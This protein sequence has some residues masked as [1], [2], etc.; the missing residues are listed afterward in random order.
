M[1]KALCST[2]GL[3]VA[4]GLLSTACG[5]R[6]DIENKAATN[7]AG[8]RRVQSCEELENAIKAD[9]I[10]KMNAQIDQQIANIRQNGYGGGGD[11]GSGG[12]I[13]A[14]AGLISPPGSAGSGGRSEGS[15][16]A[17][18]SSGSGMGGM[19]GSGT[20]GTGGSAPGSSGA[21]GGSGSGDKPGSFTGTNTQ[22]AGV[23]EAD[24]VKTDG[25]Y[26]YLLHGQSFLIIQAW[27]ASSLGQVSSFA[28]EGQPSEMYVANGKAVIYSTVDGTPEY[29][30]AGLAPRPEYRDG[31]GNGGGAP[32]GT[33][34]AGGCGPEGGCGPMP[35][36]PSLTKITVV[37]ITNNQPRVEAETY[38]EGNYVSSRRVD[39][40]VR[41]VITGGAHGPDVSYAPGLDPQFYPRTTEDW[42][43][44]YEQL[45]AENAAKIARSTLQDWLPYAMVRRGGAVTALPPVCDEFYV[46]NL[47]TTE[48]GFT[49]VQSINLTTPQERP[50][51]ASIVAMVD[52]VYA[53]AGTMVLA[54]RG[55]LS[56]PM[57]GST[58]IGRSRNP[59]PGSGSG[60]SAT[61]SEQ[62]VWIS[63]Q[64]THLHQFD[65]AQNPSTP[66]YQA[67]GTVPGSLL[68]QFSIDEFEGSLRVAVTEEKYRTD[69]Y[70]FRRDNSIYVLQVG[71]ERNLEVVG[72]ITGLAQNEQLYATRFMG[73]R[74]YVVTFRRTDPLFVLDLGTPTRPTVLGSVEIPGFSEYVHPLDE[75]HLLTIGRDG[76]MGGRGG[77]VLLQIFDV[78]QPLAPRQIQTYG[79]SS[80]A[81]GYS[82]AES[83][84]KAFTYFGDR[85]LLAFPFTANRY[86]GTYRSSLEVFHVSIDQGFAR[87]GSVDHSAFFQG[88]PNGYCGGMYG[89]DVRRGMFMD[90]FLYSISYG[91]ILANNMSDLAQPVARL[92]LPA[93]VSDPYGCPGGGGFGGAGGS[94]GAAGMGGWAG[95]GGSGG[96]GGFGP[97]AGASTDAGLGGMGGQ[98]DSGVGGSGGS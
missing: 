57:P 60:G 66:A 32:P 81:Y 69:S 77:T 4:A 16:G 2:L 21:G 44:A 75:N 98:E 72:A 50:H 30:A 91:G 14:D 40:W 64:Q 25:Q 26:I 76:S 74:G 61:G 79:F 27:P 82:E 41:T 12:W 33:G 6:I 24:F 49:Q 20:A 85:Q 22:V 87:L 73:K 17:G 51:G 5:G 19:G 54:A 8:L 43:T 95:D 45:R 80:D 96:M 15:G 59:A 84:H 1:R 47:G 83:N 62:G 52:T 58:P 55:W 97:D 37:G 78:S 56:V 93:P 67:S 94:G 9:A 11:G 38:F 39:A 48:Y 7:K 90:D 36:A 46:P 88:N 35:Y 18:G 28:I 3:L 68:N 89:T 53:N 31:Y 92:P 65:L 23:D 34:G 63:N 10:E 29:S 42:V 13:S 71:Q 70:D 86:D